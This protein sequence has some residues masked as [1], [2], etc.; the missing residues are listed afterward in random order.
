LRSVLQE[1]NGE[2]INGNF[3]YIVHH[4]L[5]MDLAARELSWCTPSRS[6]LCKAAS[7]VVAW[8]GVSGL[9]GGRARLCYT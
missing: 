4:L 9:G 6:I 8:E 3:M 2:K 1:S 5:I 7:G